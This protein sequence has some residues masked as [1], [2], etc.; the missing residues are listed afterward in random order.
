[1][2]GLNLLEE[3][4]KVKYL[5][6]WDWSPD[7]RFIAYIWDNGGVYILAGGTGNPGMSRPCSWR[8]GFQILNGCVGQT[9]FSP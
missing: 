3:F 4:L 1:M 5:G 8:Q 6:K 9:N 2:A 7:G